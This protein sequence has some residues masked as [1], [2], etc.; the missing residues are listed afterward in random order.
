M[1]DLAL[2]T[3]HSTTASDARIRRISDAV[4]ASY[5][6]DISS[7]TARGRRLRG[8]ALSRRRR[9]GRSPVAGRAA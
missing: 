2:P 8:R 5:I 3:P 1:T 6:H 7:G 9:A 4:V